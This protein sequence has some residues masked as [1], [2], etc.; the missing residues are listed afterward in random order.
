MVKIIYIK[1]LIQYLGI[2]L[3]TIILPLHNLAQTPNLRSLSGF[4]CFTSKGVVSNAGVS[5]VSGDITTAVGDVSDQ[6]LHFL[7][8]KERRI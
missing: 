5:F 4:V 8:L 7:F 6:I 1:K 2:L 3:L